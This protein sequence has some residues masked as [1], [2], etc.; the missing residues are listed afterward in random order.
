[1]NT[2][3]TER[4]SRTFEWLAEWRKPEREPGPVRPLK[5]DHCA[6]CTSEPLR[7]RCRWDGFC[8]RSQRAALMLE[9]RN[10]DRN[11]PGVQTLP[12]A[13]TDD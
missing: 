4:P 3:E 9:K 11:G 5:G 6:K 12:V 13:E 1:M 7:T 2:L 10:R 8:W